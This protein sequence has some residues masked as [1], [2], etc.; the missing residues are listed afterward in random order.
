MAGVV[1]N[2]KLSIDFRPFINRMRYNGEQIEKSV[3]S[4]G[5]KAKIAQEV[6]SGLIEP[7]YIVTGATQASIEAVER[8]DTLDGVPYTDGKVTRYAYSKSYFSDEYFYLDMD[9]VDEY[10]NHYGQYNINTEGLSQLS[11]YGLRYNKE[12]YDIVYNAV[13][14]A[15]T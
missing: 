2:Q 4:Y 5:V 12:V 15:I 10:G 14:N 3:T 13:L 6:V 9:P 1:I 7:E 8:G 11:S